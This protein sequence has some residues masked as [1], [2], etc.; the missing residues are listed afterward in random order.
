MSKRFLARAMAGTLTVALLLVGLCGCGKDP[1]TSTPTDATTTASDTTTTAPEKTTAP[2][3]DATTTPDT[4]ATDAPTT[5]PTS[6]PVPALQTG[7]ASFTI[8]GLTFELGKSPKELLEHLGTPNKQN[9]QTES[10]LG[11]DCTT[12][13]YDHVIV[14]TFAMEQ[15][16]DEVLFALFFTDDHY[17]FDGVAVGDT[18]KTLDTR[19]SARLQPEHG[20]TGMGLMG[21]PA[22]IYSTAKNVRW[23]YFFPDTEAFMDTYLAKDHTAPENTQIEIVSIQ[24]DYGNVFWKTAKEL[25]IV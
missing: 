13:Y 24:W 7:G 11:G 9:T 3:T 12:Y 21:G 17:S 15:L 16:T 25:G 4:S 10:Q 14:Q 8:D 20:Y 18:V 23:Y 2:Q 22:Y 6:E 1:D 19:I 5:E